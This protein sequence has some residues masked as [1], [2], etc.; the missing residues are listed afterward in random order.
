MKG[1]LMFFIALFVLLPALTADASYHFSNFRGIPPIHTLGGTTKIPQGMTPDEI[2]SVYHLP[3][4]GGKGTIVIIGAYD[5]AT[6]EN[7]LGVFSKTFNLPVCTTAN[8]C[9]TKHK[10]GAPKTNSG[11]VGETS[12]DVEWAH[13]IAPDAKIVL[14]EATTQSGANLLKAIDYAASVKDASAISMSWGGPE[15]PEE[16]SLDSHFKNV[17]GAPFF[18]S[19]GDDG[20]GASWPA[21]SPYVIGVG[22]TYVSMSSSGTFQKET[23]WDG[24]GGG[25]S[26]YEPEPAFQKQYSIPKAGD[27]RAIPDVSYDADPASGFPIFRA[28]KWQTVGGTS[29]GAPQWAAIAALGNVNIKNI[30]ADKSGSDN[31]KYFRDITSGTNGDCGYICNARTHYDYITGL[32][33]PLSANF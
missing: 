29:A 13:A 5:D 24:S 15:F 20:T 11:W 19:S 28:G 22:G 3:K 18:A 27:M 33:S 14:V 16:V 30:Y 21:S 26:A 8:G 23:A 6:I 9:F 4:T 17:S 7:D 10:I 1:S 2:K 12:L 32:G 31:A 25:V